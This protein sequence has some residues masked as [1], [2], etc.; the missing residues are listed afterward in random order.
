SIAEWLKK[1]P[2]VSYVVDMEQVDRTPVPEPIRQMVING[3]NRGRSGVLQVILNPGWYDMDGRTTGT[4]HG[5]WNPY[6]T[7]IPLLWFGWNIHPGKSNR[8]VYMTDISATL[9]AL[10]HI[11]MPNGCIGQ[12]IEEIVK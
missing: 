1:K 8:E 7:H 3:Y 4:T 9:A 6:D 11:Q 10:L 5:S 2:E 12:V